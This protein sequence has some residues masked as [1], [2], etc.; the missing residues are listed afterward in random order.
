MCLLKCQFV[1][2]L[3]PLN[4][5]LFS[6][7]YHCGNTYIFSSFIR[8]R[9]NTD[10][11]FCNFIRSL[12]LSFIYRGLNKEFMHALEERFLLLCN[13]ESTHGCKYF[14]GF[15]DRGLS[16]KSHLTETELVSG[17]YNYDH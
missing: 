5:V 12:K 2:S 16:L 7:W 11:L 4:Y 10:H 15:I 8:L 14:T 9:V 3:V 1:I 6:Q 17:L 13:P